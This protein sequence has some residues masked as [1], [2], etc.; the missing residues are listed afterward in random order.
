MDETIRLIGRD[1]EG[2]PSAIFSQVGA[3]ATGTGGTVFIVGNNNSTAKSV[4]LRDGGLISV[5]NF[6]TN[7]GDAAGNVFIFARGIWL[8]NDSRILGVSK[9]GAGGN[10]FLNTN[11]LILGRNSDISTTAGIQGTGGDGGNIA[12]GT[13]DIIP[14]LGFRPDG[15]LTLSPAF[16]G[17]T[18]IVAGKTFSDNNILA[19]AFSGTGGNIRINASRLQDIAERPDL[20]IR[21][22]ISTASSL[23]INGTTVVNTLD[24]FPSLRTNPLTEQ[25]EVPG[26]AQGCDPRDRQETSR[27]IVTGR[28]GLPVNP[29]EVLNQDTLSGTDPTSPPAIPPPGLDATAIIPARGWVQNADGTIRLTAAATDSS[30]PITPYPLRPTPASCDAP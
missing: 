19:E 10:V 25:Y 22:D 15:Q 18:L 8:D 17:I 27:F 28:G 7:Q 6:G 3:E 30:A 24:V 13:G 12:I 2:F 23:G 29:A 9:S 14:T 26:V 16:D 5:N 21:N 4:Q 11:A 1:A 20:L